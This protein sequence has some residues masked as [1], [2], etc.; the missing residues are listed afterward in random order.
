M[1]KI[2]SLTAVFFVS[3]LLVLPSA[4][5]MGDGGGHMQGRDEANQGGIRRRA[6]EER[7]QGT[8]HRHGD[9][10]H[11]HPGGDVPHSHDRAGSQQEPKREKVS[12]SEAPASSP[13]KT[14][15]EPKRSADQPEQTQGA[16]VSGS[17]TEIT[18]AEHAQKA[19]PAVEAPHVSQPTGVVPKSSVHG[20]HDMTMHI[21]PGGSLVLPKALQ[22]G[23]AESVEVKRFY[24]DETHVT[25]HQFVEFLN[26]TFSRIKVEGGVVRGDGEIWLL[27]GEVK[28]GYE[29]IV[30]VDGRF[31]MNGVHHAACAV[32]RVTGYGAAAYARF[33]GKRLPTETEWLHAARSGGHPPGGEI[34][35]VALARD[36]GAG[37]LRGEAHGHGDSAPSAD[38][39]PAIPTPV[40]L[41]AADANGIRGLGS[42]IG[43]WSV[44]M[45]SAPSPSEGG[46]QEFVVMGGDLGQTFEASGL[47]PGVRRYP[48]EASGDVGFRCV[49]DV[50]ED[51]LESPPP[52]KQTE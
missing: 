30:F 19:A 29:P 1:R 35:R 46:E 51:S 26:K 23:G 2:L 44:R 50:T 32:L 40:I 3:L 33:Y 38:G 18:A 45:S 48:W 11:S 28:E 4:A 37:P 12:P 6:P 47:R 27:L 39:F 20:R 13:S 15:N 41:Y 49:S 14:V 52:Q 16:G 8:V 25:N 5:M 31:S 34:S 36:A 42:N 9:Y 43:E 17:E 7:L 10:T 21:V 22:A 24:M